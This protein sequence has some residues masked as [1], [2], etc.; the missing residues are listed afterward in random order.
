MEAWVLPTISDDTSCSLVTAK[1]P[2]Q[3]SSIEAL[4]KISLIS[5]TVVGRFEINVMSAMEPE[6]TGTRTARPS[7][8]PSSSLMA[9]VTAI[10]APVVEGTMFCAP[11]RPRRQSLASGPSTIFCVAV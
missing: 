3:R 7:N 4:S 5:S 6:T 2:F 1:I 8:F 10:A 11:A 9:L